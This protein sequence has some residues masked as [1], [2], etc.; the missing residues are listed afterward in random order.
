MR[1]RHGRRARVLGCLAP[2]ALWLAALAACG[3]SG[4]GGTADDPPVVPFDTATVRIVTGSDTLAVRAEVAE[5]EE[6]RRHG[7]ME[8]RQLPDDAGMLFLYDEPQP[9]G[10]GFWMF[11]TRLPLDIA[12]LDE[13]GRIVAILEMLPCESP[14][15]DFCRSYSPGLP[16]AHALE[17]NRGY[18]ARHGVSV[19]DRVI[20]PSGVRR[21]D[22]GARP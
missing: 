2:A 1:A 6:Q 3:G 18:F 11:R 20:L 12:F 21:P 22:A 5:R 10:S 15:P 4:A 9:A 7:L 19:G 8:R 16:Y 13:D 17:V 14:N